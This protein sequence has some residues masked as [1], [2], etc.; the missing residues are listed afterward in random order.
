MSSPLADA[1]AKYK[2]ADAHADA[3]HREI[4]VYRESDA[5]DI[6]HESDPQTRD[7]VFRVK[8][9]EPPPLREW[10]LTVGDVLHN[11]RSA[12]DSLAWQLVILSTGT[13]PPEQIARKIYFPLAASPDSF[14][15]RAV[16][17]HVLPVH[18][19]LMH[20]V[21]PYQAGYGALGTLDELSRQDKHRAIH[22]TYL[23]DDD[24]TLE[25]EAVRDCK[26]LRVIYA[27]VGPL[28]DG[29]ELARIQGESTGPESEV[30]GH[31]NLTC[32][33]ALSDGTALQHL[34]DDMGKAVGRV[35]SEFEPTVSAVI[36]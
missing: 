6:V 14:F 24:F 8:V 32:H 22:P 13:E 30:N 23:I 17:E 25:P 16:L 3:L 34:L 10:G 36:L 18:R 15:R 28:E 29:G 2:R 11:L 26:I 20:D 9:R 21:Q 33:I 7:Y 5:V 35:L 4:S 27:P 1:W 19:D 12:L 31:A